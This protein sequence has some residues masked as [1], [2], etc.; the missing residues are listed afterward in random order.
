M[1][2]MQTDIIEDQI[3]PRGSTRIDSTNRN[4]VRRWL[5]AQGV[6]SP[7]ARK[8]TVGELSAAYND[9]G[10]TAV[11]ALRKADNG[12][13]K[14][15][16]LFSAPSA[17][18]GATPAANT[19]D[20]DAL[21]LAQLLT[22][23][24]GPAAAPID[25][26]R[27]V[28]LIH[29]HAA[30]P[31]A[32]NVTTDGGNPRR[33][34]GAHH[35]KLPALLKMCAAGC[36]VW[37]SGPSGSGKTHMAHQVAE[38]LDRPFYS[39]GAVTSDFRLIGFTDATGSTVRTPFREAFEH[40]G[41]FLWDEVDASNPNALVAFNQALANGSYAFPDGMVKR[42]PDFIAI[43]AANT[44]GHGPTAE[45]VGRTRI[46][47][48][49]LDRFAT[50]YIDYDEALETQLCGNERW[51]R[52]VQAARAVCQAHGIKHIVSPRASIEGA[53]LL[54]AGMDESDVAL[55]VVRKGLS[56]DSWS[57]LANVMQGA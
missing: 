43:A 28:E 24:R 14:A 33:V 21:E 29:E 41:V 36:H 15:S 51:A 39:T 55:S 17:N 45:Y 30:R 13:P 20:S 50:L 23:L 54:A 44:F 12:Q 4:L 40:G 5:C 49:T 10:S 52:K 34:D 3:G 22:R 38:A 11:D 19:A 6:D 9:E 37:L 48:A 35:E 16:G 18:N 56:D 32:I 8:L 31:T 46:D 53:R 27:I 2:A 47:G 7:V 42:H 1:A 57:K 25:E 26:T